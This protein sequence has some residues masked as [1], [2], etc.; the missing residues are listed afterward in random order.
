MLKVNC[1]KAAA[2]INKL[3][4][5]AMIESKQEL[6]RLAKVRDRFARRKEIQDLRGLERLDVAQEVAALPVYQTIQSIQQGRLLGAEETPKAVQERGGM[7]FNREAAVEAVGEDVVALIERRHGRRMFRTGE[8][9][10]FSPDDIATM[11]DA[12]GDGI[13]LLRHLATV[14][15]MLDVINDTTNKRIAEKYGDALTETP[16][17]TI[18]EVAQ[19]ATNAV[20]VEKLLAQLRYLTQDHSLV[21]RESSRL[22][23]E[24]L[25][26]R[27][28]DEVL[29]AQNK[30]VQPR[31]FEAR[32]KAA[33]VKAQEL[34]L[35]GDLTGTHEAVENHMVNLLKFRA[36]VEMRRLMDDWARQFK[37]MSARK[38]SAMRARAKRNFVGSDGENV[39]HLREGYDMILE[40]VGF[41]QPTETGAAARQKA[42]IEGLDSIIG[43]LKEEGLDLGMI[44]AEDIAVVKEILHTPRRFGQLSVHEAQS[45]AH[46]L[47]TLDS[48]ARSANTIMRGNQAI[49]LE[50]AVKEIKERLESGRE[51]ISDDL[52][53]DPAIRKQGLSRLSGLLT[54]GAAAAIEMNAIA[55]ILDGGTQGPA[56]EIIVAGRDRA[57]GI[58]EGIVQPTIERLSVA[59]NKL[60]SKV[61]WSFTKTVKTPD[62]LLASKKFRDRYP[63]SK[64][65]TGWW[66]NVFMHMGSESNQ[67]RIMDSM[68]LE[69]P[70]QLMAHLANVLPPEMADL[71]QEIWDIFDGLWEHVETLTETTNGYT[72]RKIQGKPFSFH[73]KAMR[74][75]Y[76]PLVR[77]PAVPSARRVTAREAIWSPREMPVEDLA[78]LNTGQL[79]NSGNFMDAIQAP[80]GFAKERAAKADYPV[81]LDFSVI[82]GY[83]RAVGHAA[84]FNPYLRQ[85]ARLFKDPDFEQVVAERVGLPYHREML[86]FVKDVAAE[87]SD[88]YSPNMSAMLSIMQG[89]KGMLVTSALAL[90]VRTFNLQLL[91]PVMAKFSGRISSKYL[92]QATMD[93]FHRKG[94]SH[95]P[96]AGFFEVREAIRGLSAELPMRESKMANR[97][98]VDVENFY[99]PDSKLPAWLQEL[100]RSS[101]ELLR[102]AD[103]MTTTPVW[104]AKFNQTKAELN[105][106]IEQKMMSPAEVE[107]QAAREADL[108]I[109]DTWPSFEAAMKSSI[110]RNKGVLGMLLTFYGYHSKQ[111]QMAWVDYQKVADAWRRGDGLDGIGD[112]AVSAGKFTGGMLGRAMAYG[113]GAGFLAGR[114]PAEDDDLGVWTAKTLGLSVADMVPVFGGNLIASALTGDMP[115]GGAPAPQ[116]LKEIANLSNSAVGLLFDEDFRLTDRDT[117]EGSMITRDPKRIAQATDNFGQLLAFWHKIPYKAPRRHVEAALGSVDPTDRPPERPMDD[118]VADLV[119]G[120]RFRDAQTPFH[121]PRMVRERREK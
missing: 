88:P 60:P 15:K 27:A 81:Y 33:A 38:G 79:L 31:V 61:K 114:G 23:A 32:M 10:G 65:T 1:A 97:F 2:N 106:L 5:R 113:V 95:V 53:K 55:K 28:R 109:Q 39:P 73:G 105:A 102:V 6:A 37:G 4:D 34:A 16:N 26:D 3:A 8:E 14:P 99:G 68:G 92:A 63:T 22:E 51:V 119:Y 90:N 83:V 9:K 101:F 20:Q 110:L 29:E 24:A 21:P 100:K 47:L 66:F 46:M 42:G 82:P 13:E 19:A 103:L 107:A 45:V 30:S 120:R 74:G 7:R 78:S 75:G 36:A 49:E 121:L 111:F 76:M 59:I 108:L 118:F 48:Q 70:D 104:W 84:G 43:K 64:M 40:A 87:N 86:A 11:L 80:T 115:Y 57:R 58:E 93:M 98:G 17:V 35:K 89:L 62:F 72:P 116:A 117:W 91:D 96:V 85:M 50:Q 112:F 77:D 54:S 44:K 41:R 52:Y 12:D 18:A 94:G 67:L 25:L 69:S 56:H 71:A